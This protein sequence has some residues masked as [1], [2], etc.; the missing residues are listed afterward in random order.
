MILLLSKLRKKDSKRK[1]DQQLVDKKI[2][3][4]TLAKKRIDSEIKKM[5]EAIQKMK[6]KESSRP[7]LH[8]ASSVYTKIKDTDERVAD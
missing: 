5:D 2:T 4:I 6:V 7:G 1:T 3:E 8:R